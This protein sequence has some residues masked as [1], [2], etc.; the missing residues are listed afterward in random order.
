MTLITPQ[1][2]DGPGGLSGLKVGTGEPLVLLHGVGL[3]AESW[4]YMMPSLAHSFAIT[5]IDMPGH[6]NS[7]QFDPD[8]TPGLDKYTDRVS[9]TVRS[10]AM[11]ALVVGHSMGAL[12]ALDLAIRFPELVSG[13]V[14]LN[15][16]FRRSEEASLAVQAR[17]AEVSELSDINANT[18][19][20][21]WFGNPTP[22][23]FQEMA[24]LCRA[25]LTQIDRNAYR[26]AYTVF[27]CED[28]PKD[29][30]LASLN[31][32]ALFMTGGDDPN[33]TPEMSRAMSE[34]AA[35]GLFRELLNARHMLPMTHAKEAS[36]AISEFS[37]NVSGAVNG[38]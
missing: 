28:G 24:N 22:D 4:Q 23:R 21:R 38:Y 26:Q 10:L 35:Q 18:T 19:V 5:A 1:R 12:I 2:F 11:P 20:A 7:R 34:I 13:V 30:D 3:Q 16:V 17:A 31:C 29:S 15:T 32:P 27:A 25:W 37:Q 9:E 6:G 8:T 36:A 14:A 33:S